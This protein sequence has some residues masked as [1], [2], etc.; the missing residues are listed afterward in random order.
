MSTPRRA[1]LVTA[2]LAGLTYAAPLA[3][4]DDQPRKGKIHDVEEQA[5]GAPD[6]SGV[7]EFIR[8]AG[9]LLWHLI[10]LLKDSSR[11]GQGYLD[12]PYQDPRALEHFVLKDVTTHRGFGNLS[13]SYFADAG[14][15][16]RG[17]HVAYEG[18]HDIAGLSAEYDFFREPTVEGTDY[19][20]LARL[21]IAGVG[22]LS[23][24]AYLKTGLA[25]RAMVL[26]DGR[27]ALGPEAEMG[28]QVFPLRPLAF[29][30]T[31]RI[32][33]LTGAGASWFGTALIDAA[34]G[35][36]VLVGRVELRGGFRWL[37]IGPGTSLVGPSLGAR[38]WF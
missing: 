29:D 27:V 35:A 16:L 13:A 12:Y 36:G 14:S 30:G 37:V 31:F 11:A 9:R 17:L 5:D 8:G 1:V 3:A 25:L 34:A 7:F 28:L 4:Q 26:D 18:A 21:G 2:L 24:A 6:A 23:H 19:L 20:H 32:A 38:I 33:G 22:R 10:P 15:T